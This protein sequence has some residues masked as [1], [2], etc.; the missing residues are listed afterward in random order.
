MSWIRFTKPNAFVDGIVGGLIEDTTRPNDAKCNLDGS[1][2]FSWLLRFDLAAGTLTTGASKPSANPAGPYAFIDQTV[3]L[4][5][6]PF[7]I[8]P[9]T[10]TA[11][12]AGGCS[13]D[14]SAG[15]LLLP[16][17]LDPGGASAILLPL[18]A[19][20]FSG[21]ELTP[22]HGCIGRYNAEGLHPWDSCLAPYPQ[23][24]VPFFLP[25]AE[26]DAFMTLEDADK[27][28]VDP[29]METLCV[30]LGQPAT[31]G[32]KNPQGVMVCERDAANE[33]IFK[34][35]W[36]AA[37]NQP[38]TPSCSDAVRVSASFAAQGVQIL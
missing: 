22:D 31:Y 34:G 30:V 21:G 35:D 29:L 25:G 11:P 10:L 7:H 12:L 9:V 18:R 14:S 23:P 15:D 1:G 37:T 17:Y 28:V 33:I 26:V 24:F 19:V 20:R 13:F 27:F 6:T 8:Q 16:V 36:C 32:T 4:G 2:M 38:A 5:G 3:T